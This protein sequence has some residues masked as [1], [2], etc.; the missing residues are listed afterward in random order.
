MYRDV[1]GVTI[2]VYAGS[3]EM[4]F[5]PDDRHAVAALCLYGQTFGP[6]PAMLEWVECAT[7]LADHMS[8]LE[9]ERSQDRQMREQIAEF[10]RALLPPQEH[11]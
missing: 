3:P 7:T 11:P 6:T 4:A 5:G 2:N 10:L 8:D 9:P 1:D